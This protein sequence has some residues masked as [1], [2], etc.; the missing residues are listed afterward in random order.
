MFRSRSLLPTALHL[1]L[2]SAVFVASPVV[3]GYCFPH[4]LAPSGGPISVVE[5]SNTRV[6]SEDSAVESSNTRVTSEIIAH[7][8]ESRTSRIDLARA[9]LHQLK[10]NPLGFGWTGA[11]VGDLRA[12]A[13]NE[14][15]NVALGLG[16]AGLVL[17]LAMLVA[18]FRLATGVT[19][20]LVLAMVTIIMLVHQP[21]S[22]RH[23]WVY[24]AV[25]LAIDIGHSRSGTQATPCI[26]GE[27][28]APP[29]S[30]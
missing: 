24:T 4:D 27:L 22:W 25:A 13:H 11:I 19:S 2:A 5:S 23:V 30:G 18:L 7:H 26:N 16:P 1:V 15:L 3:V 9:A 28:L 14:Y 21:M 8:D 29:N 20:R 10:E 6:T 17:L 12:E